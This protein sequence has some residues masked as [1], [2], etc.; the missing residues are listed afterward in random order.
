L[1]SIFAGVVLLLSRPV[2]IGDRVWVRS[3]PMGG[4]VRGTVTE[5]SLLY[6]RIDTCDGPA[7]LPNQQ[8][9]AAAVGQVADEPG[10]DP[11]SKRS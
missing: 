6:V 11:V 9:L 7:N 5:I 1:S 2:D 8:V 4:E 10:P 3:C